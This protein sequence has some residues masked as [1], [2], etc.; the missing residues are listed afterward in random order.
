MIVTCY[1]FDGGGNVVVVVVCV[2]FSSIGFNGMKLLISYV[3][4]SVVSS[5]GLEFSF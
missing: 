4:L 3:F 5:F 2:C 1:Y